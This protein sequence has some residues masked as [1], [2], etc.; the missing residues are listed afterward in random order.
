MI[1]LPD[2][3]GAIR[4]MGRRKLSAARKCRSWTLRSPGGEER[5]TALNRRAPKRVPRRRR[6][7]PP[8]QHSSRY[9]IAPSRAANTLD[10]FVNLMNHA[11]P[12]ARFRRRRR[13]VPAVAK[14]LE[15]LG[16]PLDVGEEEGDRPGR[17]GTH[18]R[19]PWASMGAKRSPALFGVEVR[20]RGW[21]RV[22]SVDQENGVLTNQTPL[23]SSR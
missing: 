17:Q 2:R 16:G 1:L 21:L 11:S 13:P 10:N 5:K 15:E 9:A 12:A 22:R 19:P 7:C 18:A 3:Q 23:P 14:A 4:N 8:T 6:C 20:P